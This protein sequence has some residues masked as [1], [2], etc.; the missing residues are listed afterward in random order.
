MQ[1]SVKNRVMEKNKSFILIDSFAGFF[2][3]NFQKT[4]VIKAFN[5][6]NDANILIFIVRL[7][8]MVIN[9]NV[10][11]SFAITLKRVTSNLFKHANR[12][13]Y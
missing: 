1:A 5:D 2:I 7:T 13:N 4:L 11:T 3:S 9:F 12:A 6:V 8:S 10:L